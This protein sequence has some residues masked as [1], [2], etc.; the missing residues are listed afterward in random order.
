MAAALAGGRLLVVICVF[1]ALVSF[2][3]SEPFLVA[4]LNCI[5]GIPLEQIR[6]EVFPFWSYGYLIMLPVLC[7]VAELIGY[8]AAVI[9]GAS[10][11]LLSSLVV[12]L[13]ISDGSVLAMQ[14]TQIMLAVAFAAHPALMAIMYRGTPREQYTRSGAYSG[15][16]P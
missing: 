6:Y 12:V 13:R 10:G 4:F 11:R 8:K 16:Q 7:A 15:F 14:T 5:K 9:I 2:K 1:T 3:P